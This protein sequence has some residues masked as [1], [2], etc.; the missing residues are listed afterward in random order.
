MDVDQARDDVQP[1]DVQRLASWLPDVRRDTRDPIAAD[2]HIH[3]AVV[4]IGRVDDV[5]TPQH[6]VEGHHLSVV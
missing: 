6:Q 3:D 4:S 5:S 2:G 1:G